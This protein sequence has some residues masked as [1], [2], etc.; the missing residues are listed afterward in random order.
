MKYIKNMPAQ[1]YFA[2]EAASK[3]ALTDLKR[4]AGEYYQRHIAKTKV[5]HPTEKMRLG[6]AMHTMLLEPELYTQD[7]VVMPEFERKSKT[8][9]LTISQQKAAFMSLAEASNKTVI[10]EDQSETAS[11]AEIAI[12]QNEEAVKYLDADGDAEVSFFWANPGTGMP[13]K[14]RMD[15]VLIDD[16][17]IV[18][19]KTTVDASPSGFAKQ[20]VNYGYHIQAASYMEGYNLVTGRAP[21]KFVFIAQEMVYPYMSGVYTL[22]DDSISSGIYDYNELLTELEARM[23]NNDWPTGGSHVAGETELR[24]PVWGMRPTI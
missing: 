2:V 20:I 4:S 15:K 13:C 12:R 24:I 8:Q 11:R 3:S 5:F 14:A 19:Y 21:K 7:I 23:A 17:I 6:T 18:D 1:D 9:P 22:D 16:D 10:T